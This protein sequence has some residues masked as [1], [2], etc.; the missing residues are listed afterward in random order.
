MTQQARKPLGTTR[1]RPGTAGQ[2]SPCH[3]IMAW[4]VC[5]NRPA[6]IA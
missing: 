2:F 1:T 6:V 4:Y 5:L 3:A